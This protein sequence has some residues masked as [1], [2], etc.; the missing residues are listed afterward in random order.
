MCLVR[1]SNFDIQMLQKK[2]RKERK[3]RRGDGIKQQQTKSFEK[4]EVKVSI[5]VKNKVW[6]LLRLKHPCSKS[7]LGSREQHPTTLISG[8]ACK[9]SA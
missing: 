5:W 2:K 8:H 4:G 3:R 1:V 9:N 7:L 6:L